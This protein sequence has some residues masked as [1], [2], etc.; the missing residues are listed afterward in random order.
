MKIRRVVAA[1]WCTVIIA[2]VFAA[3]VF[4]APEQGIPEIKKQIQ[5]QYAQIGEALKQKDVTLYERMH[6]SDF[7]TTTPDG[8]AHSLAEIITALSGADVPSFEKYAVVIKAMKREK[9][10]VVVNAAKQFTLRAIDKDGSHGPKGKMHTA[11][12]FTS[13]S[14][15]WVKQDGKWLIQTWQLKS[16]DK[17]LVDGKQVKI[18]KE[19]LSKMKP[20]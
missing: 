11:T 15:I 18:P 10:K 8:K 4:A 12:F 3:Q 17:L 1:R 7:T 9:D 2:A 19:M 14:D 20:R 16:V 6:T 5:A 13:D